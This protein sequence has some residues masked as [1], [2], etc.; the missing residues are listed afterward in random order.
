MTVQTIATPRFIL[1]PGP[2]IDLN[3]PLTD[4]VILAVIHQFTQTCGGFSGS[5]A[6]LANIAKCSESTVLAILHSLAD[7]RMICRIDGAWQTASIPFIPPK[8]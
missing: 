4:T 8:S 7:R 1:I 6:Y 5:A 3:L 2:L